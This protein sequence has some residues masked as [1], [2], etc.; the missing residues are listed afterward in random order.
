MASVYYAVRT[1]SSNTT[2][3]S[4]LKGFMFT[5]N[6]TATAAFVLLYIYN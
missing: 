3:V 1:G 6:G 4:P 5:L 2:D